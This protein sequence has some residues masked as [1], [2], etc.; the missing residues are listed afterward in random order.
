M[1]DCSDELI[2]GIS[3]QEMPNG[4]VQLRAG[5]EAVRELF[6]GLGVTFGSRARE[7]RTV[8]YLHG[9]D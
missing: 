9:P 5:S 4:T 1:K 7:A 8:S 2:G 6:R 3:R